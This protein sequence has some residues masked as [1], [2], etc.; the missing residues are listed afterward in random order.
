MPT[1]FFILLGRFQICKQLAA[2]HRSKWQSA[3]ASDHGQQRPHLRP[4]SG[5]T[6]QISG[7]RPNSSIRSSISDPNPAAMAD[8]RPALPIMPKMPGAIIHRVTNNPPSSVLHGRACPI[9]SCTIQRGVAHSNN[10]PI[11]SH[12]RSRPAVGHRPSN[13]M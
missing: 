6:K 12:A 7:V 3:A 9:R 2:G 5:D 1:I 13:I 4:G 8:H 11:T 10:D